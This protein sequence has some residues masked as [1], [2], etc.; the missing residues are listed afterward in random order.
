MPRLVF[1][2]LISFW[3]LGCGTESDTAHAQSTA[4]PATAS[5]PKAGMEPFCHAGVY[6]DQTA[7]DLEV[8]WDTE[9]EERSARVYQRKVGREAS[10]AAETQEKVAAVFAGA[11]AATLEALAEAAP[12]DI[13]GGGGT[14]DINSRTQHHLASIDRVCRFIRL[15]GWTTDTDGNEVTIELL[16]RIND[17]GSNTFVVTD[18]YWTLDGVDYNAPAGEAEIAAARARYGEMALPND[19]EPFTTAAYRPVPTNNYQDTFLG[20][21]LRHP[22]FYNAGTAWARFRDAQKE[23]IAAQPACQ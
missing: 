17:D 2:F 3:V 8:R 23:A 5:S 1:L 11:P 9:R 12:S 19:N 14:W 13:L 16:P 4:S 18:L 7:A 6:L 20:F 22:G 15:R 10:F 21:L